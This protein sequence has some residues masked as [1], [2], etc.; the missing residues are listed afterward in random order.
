MTEKATIEAAK[1]PENVIT[2]E[3]LTDWQKRVGLDLR[4]R[5]IFNQTVSPESIRNYSNGI[6][7]T[8]PL[9]RDPEYAKQTRFGA[10]VAHPGWVAGVLPHWLLQGLPGVHADHSASDWEFYRPVY[11]H[12]KI[13]PKCYF[14]GYDV[15]RSRFAGKTAFEYQRFEYWNQRDELVSKGYCLLVRYERQTARGKSEKGEGKYDYITVPHPWTD[16]ELDKVDEQVLAEKPRGSNTRYWEDVQIGDALEPVIKGPLGVTDFIAYTLG[17]APF[18]MSAHGVQLKQYKEHP[19]WGFRDPDTRAWEP[20]YSVH[21]SAAAARGV[22]AM[23]AYD[24][25]IQRHSWLTH[26][27]TNWMGD[28]GWLKKCNA[29]YRQFV[30]LSDVVWFQGKVINKYIDDN[31][32]YCVDVETHGINQREEDTIMGESTVILPSKEKAT[33]PAAKRLP[34]E[35]YRGTGKGVYF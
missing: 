17:A 35:E 10:L 21:Y 13:T 1:V 34:P 19:A 11:V 5:T 33:S 16:E 2:D 6:G 4:I 9:Y 14:V 22:G 7:D 28:E 23:Y 31:G 3:S 20:I 29:Q 32:E 12:D 18:Q 15:K 26:L 27:L 24:A 30:Y 25:G 8:N